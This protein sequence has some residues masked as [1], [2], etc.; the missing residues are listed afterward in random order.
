MIYPIK[1][2]PNGGM[3]K[4]LD[5][6]Y[7]GG[8]DYIDAIN[9]T[10]ISE[11][12]QTTQAVTPIKGNENVFDIGSVS[13]QNAK[14]RVYVG[15]GTSYQDAY[16]NSEFNIFDITGT[17]IV[18][19]NPVTAYPD[20][21]GIAAELQT[22][23]DTTPGAGQVLVTTDG[24]TYIDIE[25]LNQETYTFTTSK[26]SSSGVDPLAYVQY[27][28]QIGSNLTGTLKVI[29]SYDLNG[30]LFIWS[31]VRD[32]DFNDLVVQN[33]VYSA[34]NFVITIPNHGM[35][36][37]DAI[38]VDLTFTTSTVRGIYQVTVLTSSTLKISAIPTGTF[39]S[40]TASASKQA[41]GEIGVAIKDENTQDWTYTR[42][43]RSKKLNFNTLHQQDTYAE[44]NNLNP[45]L[46]FTDDYNNPR[47]FY[48][49]GDYVQDGFLTYYNSDAIYSYSTLDTETLLQIPEQNLKVSVE[50]FDTGGSLKNYTRQY[51][52]RLLTEEAN[53]SPFSALTNSMPTG[54]GTSILYFT[55]Y[56]PDAIG[57]STTKRNQITVSGVNFDQFKYIELAVVEY[58]G[59]GFSGYI[60]KRQELNGANGDDV[61]ISHIGNESGTQNL[62]VNE[63]N[64]IIAPISTAKNITAISNRLVLSN[65]TSNKQYDLSAWARTI[66][67]NLKTLWQPYVGSYSDIKVAGEYQLSNNVYASLGY[68]HNETYRFGI[69]LYLK[70]IGY[71]QA[72][73][74]DDVKFTINIE[75]PSQQLTALSD[76]DLQRTNAGVEEF[77]TNYI[78]FVN[79]NLNYALE[80]GKF[81][82][83]I[84]EGFRFVRLDCIP[85]VLFTGVCFP[86]IYNGATY[87]MNDNWFQ[88][89][90]Y[91][92]AATNIQRRFGAIVSP[93]I[94]FG[95]VD[96]QF[97][98]GDKIKNIGNAEIFY[99]SATYKAKE[100]N[101]YFN[102]TNDYTDLSLDAAALMGGS[103]DGEPTTV[104]LATNSF[105]N[106]SVSSATT[107]SNAH[108]AVALELSLVNYLQNDG[109]NTDYGFYHVQYFREKA[110]KYN[111][112]LSQK[113]KTIGEAIIDL[114]NHDTTTT[115]AQFGG[116]TFTQKTYHNIHF[117]VGGAPAVS[118]RNFIGFY[119][120]NRMNTQMRYGTT[121][122]PHAIV[123]T[124]ADELSY[125]NAYT[126]YQP[127][128]SFV[129][130]DV[131]NNNI[132]DLP[133]R[134]YYSDKKVNGSKIDSYR[135]FQPL[136]FRDLY[137]R[138]GEIIHTVNGNGELLTW[139][140]KS[141]QRQYFNNSGTLQT[142]DNSN[143]LVG[144]G[145][146]LGR[147][148]QFISQF[149]TRHKWSVVKGVSKGG[150]DTFY[151]FNTDYKKVCRFGYD[152]TVTL[153]D[154]N[155]L[156]TFFADNLTFA[157]LYDT[158]ANNYGIHGVW[159]DR[160]GEAIWTVRA[161]KDVD[162]FNP[163][164]TYSI[165]DEVTQTGGTYYLGYEQLPQIYISL[166]NSNYGSNVPDET[167][168][169]KWELATNIS[170]Y[171]NL[172]TIS[173]NEIKN[174]FTTFYSHKPKIYLRY[175]NGYL[176]QVPIT[177]NDD[178]VP[179]YEH[180]R[181]DYAAWYCES[182]TEAGT[183]TV[184]FTSGSKSVT[185]TGSID[186]T[187]VFFE[188]EVNYYAISYL[189]NLYKV[190]S[191][192][193]ALACTLE[194]ESDVTH[195]F[196]SITYNKCCSE[197][198]YI[199]AV[200]NYEPNN[201]KHFTAHQF[202]T[203]I[204][205]IQVIDT[206]KSHQTFIDRADMEYREDYSY[207]DIR[208][209]IL[210]SSN[211]EIATEDTSN[212]F[213]KFLKTKIKFKSFEYNKLFNFITKLRFSSRTF[214]K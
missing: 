81:L 61:A 165:G 28:E 175:K 40:G 82:S 150:N 92:I 11:V 130:F 146:V 134:I 211:G 86:S 157:Q 37:G 111:E 1:V 75:N 155:G 199:E 41:V 162:A 173:Y 179:V 65:I 59:N 17:P 185:A 77:A 143:L 101:G 174:K 159:H 69:Q 205:P 167:I 89:V 52:V 158:P 8:G 2:T 22:E 38:F 24:S 214:N 54:E 182:I 83:D 18:N 147:Q 212:L 193:S 74:I 16:N 6:L 94:N 194:E 3:Q 153:S 73:F 55:T 190:V 149:G 132:S 68:M 209:D 97:T 44:I 112:L 48:Y 50:Q 19:F 109:S 128:N 39:V 43:I 154:I 170:A 84:C 58:A 4:D 135:N 12:G 152:G 137:E 156:K 29:G 113:Y 56:D 72:Y 107:W 202:N 34:P 136:N 171:Y 31:A 90:A 160:L 100:F 125:D 114:S 98:S 42:L 93:D 49:Y 23:F 187:S 196:S 33:A 141:F 140:P 144:D 66:Q 188:P 26:V 124:N 172:F 145:S 119:S 213:G 142:T 62:D 25:F 64:R 35:V 117:N 102:N 201:E 148:G 63:L 126:P 13:V 106:V 47:V 108:K 30:E 71:T 184:V 183:Y 121:Y 191:V 5:E 197:N 210:T 181:G 27:K 207:A 129:A 203:D 91:P 95:I 53:P 116:D 32:T 80:D 105:N 164:T 36:T 85:E 138:D 60:V 14:Y 110:D 127:I 87:D 169:T 21:T 198:P 180:N 45:V 189:G 99:D 10:H 7:V 96:F 139:Q 131:D 200:T 67:Y 161:L 103:L 122:Q 104:A 178:T 123:T 88:G 186:F 133:T 120:Q 79:I 76:Y 208:N 192:E 118:D 168:G 15:T 57:T 78:E 163:D 195:T 46:Y 70:G 151:W 177:L 176:S 166:I 51:A 115:Y 206:T 9:V 20:W 204:N